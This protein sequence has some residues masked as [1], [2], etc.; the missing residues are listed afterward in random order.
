MLS[1]PLFGVGCHVELVG[2]LAAAD[3]REGTASMLSCPVPMRYTGL[4]PPFKESSLQ[5][6]FC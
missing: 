2:A 4:E 3:E 1:A 5:K 6:F